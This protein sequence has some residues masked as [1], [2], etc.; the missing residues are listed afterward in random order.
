M[1]L[2]QDHELLSH[3][4]T[5]A[6]WAQLSFIATFPEVR[7]LVPSGDVALI[8]AALA[9]SNVL[10]LSAA[11]TSVRRKTPLRGMPGA[12][13]RG[14]LVLVQDDLWVHAT[15]K[16]ENGILRTECEKN[17]Q[18]QQLGCISDD[19]VEAWFQSGAAFPRAIDIRPHRDSYRSPLCRW[20]V[21]CPKLGTHA[22]HAGHTA[23]QAARAEELG[24]T[25]ALRA[26]GG[27]WD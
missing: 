6:G 25:A 15:W 23:E 11:H 4:G 22:S 5:H 8:A 26:L 16:D 2:V 3:M 27:R 7:G 24:V 19:A 13:M 12:M 10:E 18:A 14:D 20:G 17:Q 1:A 9:E 21:A